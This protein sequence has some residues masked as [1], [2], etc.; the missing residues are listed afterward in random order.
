[1]P[2]VGQIR[3]V[4][5]TVALGNVVPGAIPALPKQGKIGDLLALASPDGNFQTRANLYFCFG[6]D[7]NTGSAFWG[8]LAFASTVIGTK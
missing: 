8:Q 4:P 1:L 7:S 2:P 5:H 3:L 6:Y